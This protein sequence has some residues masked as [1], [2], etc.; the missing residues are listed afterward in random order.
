MNRKDSEYTS[1]ISQEQIINND[2]DLSVRRYVLGDGSKNIKQLENTQ[3]L[4]SLVDLIRAQL[5]K[6]D[7]DVTDGDEFFEVGA[8]D[9]GS[10]GIVMQPTKSMILSGR[11]RDRA[12]LQQIQPGDIILSTKGA[13]G[14]VAIVGDDC[15]INWV[16]N[17]T[18]QVLRLKSPQVISPDYLYMYLTSQ[19]IQS[20]LAEQ[21][22][23]AG[24]QVLKTGDVRNLPIQVLQA[25]QQQEITDTRHAILNDYEKINTLQKQ[26]TKLNRNFWS[27]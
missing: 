6:Q 11:M 22:S 3:P 8:R 7:K 20:Y 27:Y 15:G 26:I 13:I 9:I 1:F 17:Q 12:N 2:F 23:G 19:L 24:I 5:L 21:A 10:N 18:F 4:E 16:V 25:K 14:K